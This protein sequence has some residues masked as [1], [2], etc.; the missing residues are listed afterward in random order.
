MNDNEKFLIDNANLAKE[1]FNKAIEIYKDC[2]PTLP[3]NKNAVKTNIATMQQNVE[4]VEQNKKYLLNY[5]GTPKAFRIKA[6]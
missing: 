3:A 4:A 5:Y 1:K 2:K 6:L